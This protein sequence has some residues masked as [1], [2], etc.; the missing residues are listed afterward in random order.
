MNWKK[1][2]KNENSADILKVN[3]IDEKSTD[4]FK[5][6]STAENTLDIERKNDR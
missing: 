4:V 5:A 1:K 6:K 3:A 2:T